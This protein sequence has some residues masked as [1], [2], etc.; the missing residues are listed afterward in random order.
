MNDASLQYLLDRQEISD[1]I[2]RFFLAMD[3]KDWDGVRAVIADEFALD[4]S[5]VL[6]ESTAHKPAGQ[7]LKELVARNGGFDASLHANPNHLATIDGDTAHATAYMMAAHWVGSSPED[8][9]WGYGYYDVDLV[10]TSQGWRMTR[11]VLTTWHGEGGDPGRIFQIAAER[12]QA[13]T[14]GQS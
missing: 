3:R 12:Q 1:T 8:R 13:N 7:F 6:A 11:L 9:V 5:A 10:R 14:E 4:A 2:T